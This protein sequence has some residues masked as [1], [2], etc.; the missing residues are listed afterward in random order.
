MCSLRTSDQC[1]GNDLNP[2]DL[3]DGRIGSFTPQD[4]SD[5]INS[6]KSLGNKSWIRGV[7]RG[8]DWD[9]FSFSGGGGLREVGWY[10]WTIRYAWWF[11]GVCIKCHREGSTQFSSMT[12]QH[13]SSV[14][15][16]REKWAISLLLLRRSFEYGRLTIGDGIGNAC[17][18]CSE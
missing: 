13:I 6:R 5:H 11:W 3:N 10:V 7:Q 4:F 18:V 16:G 1:S 15:R 17:C 8:G 14:E 2:T 9:S 12:R